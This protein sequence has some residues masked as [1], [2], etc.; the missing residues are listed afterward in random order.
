MSSTADSAELLSYRFLGL[1]ENRLTLSISDTSQVDQTWKKTEWSRGGG[2]GGGSTLHSPV[3]A[4]D[5]AG[6]IQNERMTPEN[7][8]GVNQ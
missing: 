1:R 7:W 5:P 8:L 4:L 3:S 6:K 2:V